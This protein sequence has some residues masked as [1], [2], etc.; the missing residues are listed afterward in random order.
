MLASP[1]VFHWNVHLGT[2]ANDFP[3]DIAVDRDASEPV[4]VI[5]G[6]TTRGL[7]SNAQIGEADCF[8]MMYSRKG[9]LE[10]GMAPQE[11]QKFLWASRMCSSLLQAE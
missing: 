8:V 4:G 10:H 5:A 3:R 2:D 11:Q 1:R 9:L 6:Y 7:A